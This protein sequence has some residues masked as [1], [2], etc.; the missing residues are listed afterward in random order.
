MGEYAQPL[1]AQYRTPEQVRQILTAMHA[2]RACLFTLLLR[3]SALR[4]AEA[5]DL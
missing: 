3:R 4:Q 1:V 5:L 2:G